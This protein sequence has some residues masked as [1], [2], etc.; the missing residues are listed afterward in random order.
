M[1]KLNIELLNKE[2]EN[3]LRCY[4]CNRKTNGPDD[5]KS[6]KTGKPVK[7]CIK[8]RQSVLKSFSKNPIINSSKY[9]RP[10]RIK[11][12]QFL[13]DFICTELNKNKINEFLD[14]K[15]N[16]YYKKIL[17]ESIDMK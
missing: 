5:Y 2:Y 3:N 7:T 16:K 17:N 11:V 4:K 14:K 9:K 13:Y 10:N 12:I 15:E 1:T 6:L 8:C